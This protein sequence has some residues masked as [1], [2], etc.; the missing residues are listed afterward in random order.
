MPVISQNFFKMDGVKRSPY[1]NPLGKEFYFCFISRKSFVKSDA[2]AHSGSYEKK[3]GQLNHIKFLMQIFVF[4]YGP[5][6]VLSTVCRYY[7]EFKCK[8]STGK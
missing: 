8:I 3:N 2:V 7:L 6:P 4:L 5:V 1:E